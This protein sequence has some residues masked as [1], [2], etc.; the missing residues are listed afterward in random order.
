V[1]NNKQLVEEVCDELVKARVAHDPMAS[2]H[3]AYAVILEELDEY[4]EHVKTNPRKLTDEARAHRLVEMRKEL[5]Q[6]AAMALRAI[7]DTLPEAE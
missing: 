1:K 6:I 2:G 4:W 7:Q 5:I 3:E